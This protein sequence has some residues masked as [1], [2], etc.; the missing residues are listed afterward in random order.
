[1]SGESS[2]AKASLRADA[3]RNVEQLHRAAIAAFRGRGLDTPLE[4]IAAAAGVA[5]GTIYNRFGGRAG[6]IDAVI[7]ELVGHEM[8]AIAQ[9]A[10]DI[11]DPWE[12]LAA[13]I[14]ERRQLHY[15]EPSAIDALLVAYPESQQL[16][17]LASRATED[18][19]R[20]LGRARDA[21]R[22][23]PDFTA[24]D[25]Y[26]ADVGNALALRRLPRPSQEDYVRRT[27]MFLDGIRNS[28]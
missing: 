3:T 16:R 21:R 4:E 12:A 20:V 5:K 8:D 11:A 15:Y 9:R 7:G 25:L 2:N 10:N 1:M 22:V 27:R 19:N 24:A 17:D 26:E 6:L 23:R 14:H 13:Y 28:P 18:A